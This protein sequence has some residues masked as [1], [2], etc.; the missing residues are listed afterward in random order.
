VTSIFQKNETRPAVVHGAVNSVRQLPVG[1]P[2]QLKKGLQGE[3][4]KIGD[5]SQAQ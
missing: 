2:A 5:I 3:N 4:R 1:K